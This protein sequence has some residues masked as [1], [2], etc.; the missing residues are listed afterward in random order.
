MKRKLNCIL[1]I[2]DDEPTNY[3]NQEVIEE[4]DCADKVVSKLTALEALEYLTSKEDGE[5]PRPDLILLD[6]NMPKMNGFEFMQ[7]YNNLDEV[8]KGKIV[9]IML[10]T[11]LNPDD[12]AK[13]RT[14]NG[15]DDY[16]NKPLTEELLKDILHTYF[17]DHF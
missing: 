12:E 3:L 17:A 10:T 13:A 7:A 9:I 16:K 1:L 5:H 2:D 15:I 11:S 14:I 4:V 6:I 8:Q